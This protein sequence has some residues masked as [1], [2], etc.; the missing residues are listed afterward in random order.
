MEMVVS[1]VDGLF[2]TFHY[3]RQFEKKKQLMVSY[4]YL[5]VVTCISCLRKDYM[6]T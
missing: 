2:I 1:R 3:I 6:W 5:I 4:T